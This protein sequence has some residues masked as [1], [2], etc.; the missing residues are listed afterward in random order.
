MQC[1]I[2]QTPATAEPKVG[3]KEVLDS[4]RAGG[5]YSIVGS[6][7]GTVSALAVDKKVVLTTW[8]CDQRRL[9][10]TTPALDSYNIKEIVSRGQL[11]FTQRVER[12]LLFLAMNNPKIG[13]NFQLG[14]SDGAPLRLVA[15]SG[16]ED[17]NELASLLVL[18]HD[19][20]L[21]RGNIELRDYWRLSP[22][23][24]T[25]VEEITARAVDATQGFVAMWFSDEVLPA[26]SDGISPAIKDAGYKPLRI[27]KVEH[28]D[29]VDDRIIAEIRRSRFFVADFSCEKEK[30]RGGVYYE[31]GFAEGINI[32]IF[33]TCRKESIEDLHFDTR[34][35]N[36][37]VWTDPADLREKLTN[38]IRAIIGQGPL[39]T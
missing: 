22:L 37:I 28:N 33:W 29:K 18:M 23:G 3:D 5:K 25:R 8:L 14:R 1:F 32:P 6:I 27:D 13:A 12:T 26:W 10:V 35:Y 7:E 15:E 20:G 17:I 11:T 34:Q 4:P 38:R 39:K 24:W 36:H 9:G 16:S 31:A 30:A 2:W 21:V 19:M